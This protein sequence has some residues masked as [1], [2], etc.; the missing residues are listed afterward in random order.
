MTLIKYKGYLGSIDFDEEDRIFHGKL[1]FIRALVTY[2]ATN[3]NEL[4]SAFH[5]AVEDYLTLCKEQGIKPEKPLK[6]S[7]NI[8]MGPDLY[9]KAMLAATHAG[10]SL[11]AFVTEA[12]WAAVNISGKQ[13]DKSF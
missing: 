3:A 10:I 1:E 5:Q 6:G 13:V 12:L 9:R 11:N 2:E 8:N 4:V 7:F